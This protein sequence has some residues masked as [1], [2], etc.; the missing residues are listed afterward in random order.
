M[1]GLG[2][3]LGLTG[4]GSTGGGGG[5]TS[6]NGGGGGG[7]VNLPGLPRAVPGAAFQKTQELDPFHLESFGV[8]PGLGTM[9]LQGV[10]VD[11]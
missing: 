4:K 2:T 7:L 11:R 10:A 8:D 6:G 5:G 3:S 1:K 9:L